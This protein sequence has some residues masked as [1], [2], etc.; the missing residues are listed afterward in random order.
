MSALIVSRSCPWPFDTATGGIFHRLQL[1]LRAASRV[2]GHLDIL[3]FVPPSWNVGPVEAIELQQRLQFDWGV[4]ASVELVPWRAE[5]THNFARYY[6]YPA[7]DVRAQAGYSRLLG[8]EQA[9]AVRRALARGPAWVLAHRLQPWVLLQQTGLPL[10]RVVLDLDDLEHRTLWQASWHRPRWLMER[11]RALQVPALALAQRRAVGA[12]SLTLVCSDVDARRLRRLAPTG[13]LAVLPNP[14]VHL[15]AQVAPTEGKGPVLAYVGGYA[16]VPNAQAADVL[17]RDVFPIVRAKIPQARLLIVGSHPELI[18]AHALGPLPGVEYLGF[19]ENVAEVYQ[20][21]ALVCCPIRSGSGTRLKIIE[22]AAHGVP[23][24]STRLGAEGLTFEDGI[25]IA[26]A[27][28]TQELAARC[29]QLLTAPLVRARWAQAARAKAKSEYAMSAL[30][31]RA[32]R[33]FAESEVSWRRSKSEPP[34]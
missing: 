33:L 31:E 14:A 9:Q 17:V 19:V 3:F 4:T 11:L 13:A 8:P 29:L 7:M 21:A 6:L 18:P 25:E 16:F 26:M 23:A 20:E 34:Y 12:S 24:V 5:L 30:V 2:A 27:D 32:A 22:A 15:P 10:P 28:T 1:L